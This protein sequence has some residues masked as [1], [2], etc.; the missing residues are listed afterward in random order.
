MKLAFIV[1]TFSACFAE[2]FLVQV[3]PMPAIAEIV[4]SQEGK[5]LEFSL[6]IDKGSKKTD[7]ATSMSLQGLKLTLGHEKSTATRLPGA[8]GPTPQLSS[9]VQ[10]ADID[11]LPF[12][13][14]MD[15]TQT[16]TV[17]DGCWEIV[18]KDT[19]PHGF[20]FCGLNLP[21]KVARNGVSLPVG[22]IYL[23]HH[24][25]SRDTLRNAQERRRKAEEKANE[26]LYQ[27]KEAVLRMQGTNNL[28][29]KAKLYRIALAALEDYS[30]S[31]VTM[32]NHVPSSDDVIDLGNDFVMSKKGT[33]L[34]MGNASFLEV[35]KKIVG[36]TFLRIPV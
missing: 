31:G 13:V 3:K 11:E 6:T 33:I 25:W 16:V 4:K 17:E 34:T 18:W 35:D 20:L 21:T 5:H 19:S 9:G 23:C 27:R 1:V 12:F 30:T 10:K 32:L 15:G 2:A 24:I 14:N 26:C 29:E 8:N 22:H 28:F 36:S 7:R